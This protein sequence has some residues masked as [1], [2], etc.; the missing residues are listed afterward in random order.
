MEAKHYKNMWNKALNRANDLDKECNSLTQI[1][2]WM[3]Q[4]SQLGYVLEEGYDAEWDE[5]LWIGKKGDRIVK[6]MEDD[7]CFV[8]GDKEIAK[9]Q[10]W[11]AKEFK[12]HHLIDLHLGCE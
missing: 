5:D 3:C 10:F 2:I 4:L 1:M 6:I 11:K 8:L 12:L 9:I 7:I